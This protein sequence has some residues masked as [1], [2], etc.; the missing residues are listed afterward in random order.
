VNRQD[1]QITN[2]IISSNGGGDKMV[3]VE[4]DEM[5]AIKKIR[6]VIV[7]WTRTPEVKY[8]RIKES[9]VTIQGDQLV[10]PK[11]KLQLHLSKENI[12]QIS[13]GHFQSLELGAVVIAFQF[14]S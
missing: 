11:I 4:Q 14:L 2:R 6:S 9:S 1:Y 13:T 3:E 5:E 7:T 10:M 12:K 8:F